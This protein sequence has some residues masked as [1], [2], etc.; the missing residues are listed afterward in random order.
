MI[1][2]SMGG[3]IL[4]SSLQHLDTKIKS[5]LHT[6]ISFASPHLGYLHCKSFITGT[7]IKLI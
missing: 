3:I 7:G 1:G 5:L 6:Y 4:R 2:H